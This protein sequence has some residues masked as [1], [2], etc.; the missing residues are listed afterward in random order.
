MDICILNIVFL[1]HFLC[2][3]VM[4]IM[5]Q[6]PNLNAQYFLF[7]ISIWFSDEMWPGDV[8]HVRVSALRFTRRNQV[9]NVHKYKQTSVILRRRSDHVDR[10][11]ISCPFSS[12]NGTCFFSVLGF[13]LISASSSSFC[14]LVNSRWLSWHPWQ[15]HLGKCLR[16]CNLMSFIFYKTDINVARFLLE[17]DL[18][19]M[20]SFVTWSCFV[21]CV[22]LLSRL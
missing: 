2:F 7:H 11:C 6:C 1:L 13:F 12:I 20:I 4:K 3:N 16:Y 10:T 17:E 19:D 9:W 22:N 15:V 8:H 21:L 18:S 14:L 5:S